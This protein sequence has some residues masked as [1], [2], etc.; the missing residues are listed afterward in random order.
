[1]VI[2]FIDCLRSGAVRNYSASK[3][4]II[5]EIDQSGSDLARAKETLKAGDYKWSTIQAY[6]SMFHAARAVLFSSGYREKSH[7]CI[8]FS[9]KASSTTGDWNCIFRETS[10]RR[11]SCVR[12]PIM[13]RLM[14]SR[15]RGIPLKTHLRLSEE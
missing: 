4:E 14:P 9:L 15:A 12:K 10:S 11:C 8:L 3:D 7:K 13:R 5:K 2:D 6:Y 1:M